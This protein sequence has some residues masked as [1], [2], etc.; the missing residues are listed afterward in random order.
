LLIKRELNIWTPYGMSLSV[1]I[2]KISFLSS[3]L[4][5]LRCESIKGVSCTRTNISTGGDCFA[6]VP[7]EVRWFSVMGFLW[8]RPRP[9]FIA[10]LVGLVGFWGTSRVG[11]G[12]SS[13]SNSAVASGSSSLVVASGLSGSTL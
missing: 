6:D 4:I 5:S 11:K 3:P 7:M 10:G 13:L 1:I 9:R 8:G 2:A 12:A